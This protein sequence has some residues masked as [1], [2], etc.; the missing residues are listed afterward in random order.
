MATQP[1]RT[2]S[3]KKV[4]LS[5]PLTNPADLFALLARFVAA[6]ILLVATFMYLIQGQRDRAIVTAVVSLLFQLWTI[7]LWRKLR[8]LRLAAKA[9]R[10][11]ALEEMR[12]AE[13]AEPKSDT[14]TTPPPP[15]VTVGNI[16][17]ARNIPARD[18]ESEE[19]EREAGQP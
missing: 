16:A 11:A 15:S 10:A 14:A 8:D 7:S 17:T 13:E 4:D 2:P 5:K 1:T 18:A 12:A 3:G 19:S 9:D 6:N